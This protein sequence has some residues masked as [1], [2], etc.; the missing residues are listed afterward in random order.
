LSVRDKERLRIYIEAD[1]PA[2][3]NRASSCLLSQQHVSNSWCE[4]KKYE[5][6]GGTM[7]AIDIMAK[8]S[9]TVTN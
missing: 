1:L 8:K 2:M 6:I 7:S 3:A 9:S 5:I 4:R